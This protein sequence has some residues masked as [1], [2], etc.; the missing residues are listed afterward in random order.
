MSDNSLNAVSPIDGRYHLKTKTLEKYFSE[1]ALIRYRVK[2]EIEYFIALCELPLPE[3][4]NLKKSDYEKLRSYYQ[5][6][7]NEDAINNTVYARVEN[8]FGC[9]LV[10]TV[11]LEVSTTSLPLGFM[12]ELTECDDD[13]NIDGIH[14]FYCNFSQTTTVTAAENTIR[15]YL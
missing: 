4:K 14:S 1:A 15:L 3:L 11:T 9:F 10:S 12:E 5:N 13:G 7:N 6:F 8:I 2:V